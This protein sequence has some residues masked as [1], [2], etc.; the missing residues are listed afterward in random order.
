MGSIGGLTSH[1]D[2]STF[3][4]RWFSTSQ[5]PS[6]WFDLCVEMACHVANHLDGSTFGVETMGISMVPMGGLTSQQ[7]SGWFDFWIKMVNNEMRWN[8]FLKIQLIS[9]SGGLDLRASN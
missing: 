5:Q 6:G 7:P 4:S 1:L 9:N 3:R 2:G 8:F